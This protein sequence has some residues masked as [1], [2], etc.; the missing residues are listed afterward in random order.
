MSFGS[1]LP[2]A[3]A[4]MSHIN[5][6][7]SVKGHVQKGDW[8]GGLVINRLEAAFRMHPN[9]AM[10]VDAAML[11]A[12]PD[13]PTDGPIKGRHLIQATGFALGADLPARIHLLYHA[14]TRSTGEPIYELCR[15]RSWE[16]TTHFHRVKAAST[17]VAE[18]LN[19]R[20]MSVPMFTHTPKREAD[21]QLDW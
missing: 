5:K 10:N 11:V 2:T 13:F 9:A 19:T 4:E 1:D 21:E 17:A 7:G 20:S 15:R 3:V 8:T 16:R 14:H 18:W 12:W 6:T